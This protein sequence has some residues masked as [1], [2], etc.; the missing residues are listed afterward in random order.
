M[1]TVDV[2]DYAAA[3]NDT[4][5]TLVTTTTPVDGG[6]G[7][8]YIDSNGNTQSYTIDYDDLK[9]IP[10]S[11]TYPGLKDP[12][13]QRAMFA[14]G[15]NMPSDVK[16]YFGGNGYQ[17]DGF[18]IMGLMIGESTGGQNSYYFGTDG[19]SGAERHVTA[20]TTSKD[21]VAQSLVDSGICT[22]M[23]AARDKVNNE[24]FYTQLAEV[25]TAAQN[26]TNDGNNITTGG[27]GVI[28]PGMKEDTNRWRENYVNG[29]YDSNSG[30]T[31][32][33]GE[34]YVYYGR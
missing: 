17:L 34:R 11:Q 23:S 30:G 24:A 29:T 14:V 16:Q 13:K 27:W 15:E 28:T 22:D 18:G 6:V 12:T 5:Q 32:E 2:K 19:G 20:T 25:V 10:F 3:S 7:I 31:G 4:T 26:A 33:N 9:F 21:I 8:S 1:G